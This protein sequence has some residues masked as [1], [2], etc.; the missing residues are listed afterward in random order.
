M[1][2]RACAENRA[3]QATTK[4]RPCTG[5]A[6]V[7][8]VLFLLSY[9]LLPVGCE[10][11]SKRVTVRFWNV[12]TGP[13]GRTM[14]RMVKRFNRENPDIRVLMQRIEWPSY[15]NKLFIAGLGGRAPEVCVIHTDVLE[16]FIQAGFV[17]PIDE[18]LGGEY[19]LDVE[20][21]DANVWEA[22][23]KEGKHYALPLDVH[24]L[25]LYYNKRLFRQ[26]G[27]VDAEGEAKPP[28]DRQEFLN[29]AKKLTRDLD[30]DGTNDQW[31]FVYTWLRT[32]V[33][34]VM[35]Q[36][37]GEAFN[38]ARTS[39]LLNTQANVEA[40]QFC[41]DL[42]QEY[43]VA[44]SPEHFDAWI[45][46]RQGKV[47]MALEGIYMLPD[48]EKQTDLDYAGVPVPLFGNI[49]ATWASSHNLCIRSDLDREEQMASWRFVK[50]LS[51]HSVDWALG[52]QV[53]VRK[54]L[55]ESEAFRRLEVQ[56]EFAKQIP[57]VKY[58]PR[59]PFILEFYSEFDLAVEK[60]LRGSV[61]PQ[62][63]LDVATVNVNKVIERQNA[64]LHEAK[65]RES[66]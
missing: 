4:N 29:A 2:N 41:A 27:I 55:R 44:P 37:G 8:A 3:D 15:Y 46:F 56:S 19:G 57:Y 36:W 66:G 38:E 25:G 10:R 49:L 24:P 32:N 20:D 61:S 45:G 51:D 7:L 33:Y 18:F 39:C 11:A 35:A 40:L 13:D 52:G 14:L 42:V 22:V 63:A 23:E 6:V 31:G 12:F 64:M 16:R 47:G 34:A 43:G 9:L 28:T 21:F 5:I 62:E 54:S 48:L 58:M 53:P 65:S 30:G 1:I 59:V 17:H 60:A 26:A 50:Y